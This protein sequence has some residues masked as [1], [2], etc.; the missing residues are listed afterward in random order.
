MLSPPS[1]L[2]LVIG[3]S[4]ILIVCGCKGKKEFLMKFLLNQL[5]ECGLVVGFCVHDD[6]T[7]D[8]IKNGKCF[9]WLEDFTRL[10]TLVL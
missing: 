3:C 6:D 8:F 7:T 9:Y 5:R 4:I 1:N 10:D 2:V